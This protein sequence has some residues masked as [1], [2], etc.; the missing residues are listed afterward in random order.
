MVEGDKENT[1]NGGGKRA[2]LVLGE[3]GSGRSVPMDVCFLCF[4]HRWPVID[5]SFFVFSA[6]K[7]DFH[8]PSPPSTSGLRACY[9][10][11]KYPTPGSSKTR[12]IPAF[13]TVLAARLAMAMLQDLLSRFSLEVRERQRESG[14]WLNV[15]RKSALFCLKEREEHEPRACTSAR[16]SP[17]RRRGCALGSCRNIRVTARSKVLRCRSRSVRCFFSKAAATR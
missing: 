6:R 10:V 4:C 16:G 15:G 13:G 3:R 11:S 1:A 5:A 9:A 12:L 14:L 17:P 7:A 2:T 8:L